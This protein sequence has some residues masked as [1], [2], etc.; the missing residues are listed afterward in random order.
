[1]TTK[2]V[3]LECAC[4]GQYAGEF[5]QHW[6]Q[7]KGYGVCQK[8]VAWQRGRGVSEEE[9]RENYGKEGVNFEGL[10]LS[11]DPG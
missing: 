3:D 1:M 6:N 10:Q 5:V 9:I 8:C 7:D 11:G 2:L 4:C